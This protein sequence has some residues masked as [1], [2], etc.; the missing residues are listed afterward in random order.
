MSDRQRD[1]FLP[2]QWNFVT[3]R[4]DKWWQIRYSKII[5]F[6]RVY[7]TNR[8]I[9]VQRGTGENHGNQISGK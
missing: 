8:R 7:N 9:E 6:M 5:N 3:Y 4:A 1:F 2:Y